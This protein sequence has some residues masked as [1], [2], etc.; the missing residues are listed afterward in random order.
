MLAPSK[1]RRRGRC[2]RLARIIAMSLVVLLGVAESAL[3][4]PKRTAAAPDAANANGASTLRLVMIEE[5]GCGYCE[6][7]HAEV[8]PGYPLSDEGRLAPL[9][10]RDRREPDASRFGRI[11]F[12]P[13][14]IL[15]HDG[16]EIGRILGYPGAD[17]FWSM[18]AELLRKHTDAAAQS[19]DATGSAR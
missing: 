5:P 18:L 12:T 7:W 9:L 19:R 14:F 15:T 2:D 11:V 1:L 8:G 3:P 17:F 13:T 6:R 10:R 4:G 16:H